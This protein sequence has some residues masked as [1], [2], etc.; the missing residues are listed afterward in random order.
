[1]YEFINP[2]MFQMM[3]TLMTDKICVNGVE[4]D[5]NIFTPETPKIVLVKEASIFD[6]FKKKKDT[7]KEEDKKKEDDGNP[8]IDQYDFGV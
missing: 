2:M 5:Q 8:Y 4:L 6:K 3:K 7:K 1:M